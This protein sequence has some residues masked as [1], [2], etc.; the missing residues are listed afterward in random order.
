[1][2]SPSWQISISR[3]SRSS[4]FWAFFRKIFGAWRILGRWHWRRSFWWG[5]LCI[6]GRWH[7]RRSFWWGRLCILGRWHWRRSF[8]WGRLCILGRWHWRRSFWWG[9]LCNFLVFPIIRFL[10]LRTFFQ[11]LFK[12]FLLHFVTAMLNQW[13]E[14]LPLR[15]IKLTDGLHQFPVN[16]TLTRFCRPEHGFVHSLLFRSWLI[17]KEQLYQS[18]DD[19]HS[20]NS[21]LRTTSHSGKFPTVGS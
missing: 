4:R 7:W 10:F 3:I 16:N 2:A 18:F 19:I 9:R 11:L 21:T 8:W 20:P 17:C 14:M 1:M 6:L 5:R 15:M 13:F 12:G